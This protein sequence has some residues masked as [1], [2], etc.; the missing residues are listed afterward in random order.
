MKTHV[1]KLNALG[2]CREASKYLGPIEFRDNKGEW[3]AF[4]ILETPTCLVF[5][6]ACNVGFL[7]SGFIEREEGESVDDTLQ[8]LLDDLET[9]Y[10][11]GP[12]Y[13]TR[14]TTNERM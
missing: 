13:T 3:H 14:I 10:N 9:Y 7:E 5:G 8:E 4:E 2:A 6:G 11:D 12:R 1:Q